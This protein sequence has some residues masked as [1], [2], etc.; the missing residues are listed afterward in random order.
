MIRCRWPDL[1]L[2]GCWAAAYILS[3]SEME[4]Y[5]SLNESSKDPKPSQQ[6]AYD[7][8]IVVLSAAAAATPPAQD[9]GKFGNEL[10]T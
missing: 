1:T 9:R 3:N 2:H 5:Q 10:D 6:S 4:F 7:I 8:V